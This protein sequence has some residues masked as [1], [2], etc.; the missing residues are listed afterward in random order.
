MG[1]EE[2]PIAGHIH[3]RGRCYSGLVSD[4]AEKNFDQKNTT[5]MHMTS[6]IASEQAVLG[7][8]LPLLKAMCA[9]VP[10]SRKA[11]HCS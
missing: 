10:D 1:K 5:H 9:C 4:G 3:M 6:V 11:S 7:N 8:L 2:F